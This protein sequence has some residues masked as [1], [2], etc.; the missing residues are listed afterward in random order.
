[1]NETDL[2]STSER[3][4]E[5]I[6]Q[7]QYNIKDIYQLDVF[8]KTYQHLKENLK[9]LLDIKD[10]MESKGYKTPYFALTNHALST[11]G[12]IIV[13]E[14]HEVN[15][16]NKYF[17]LKATAKKNIY[18]RTKSA[19]ASH[20]IILGI[21][22]ESAIIKC[23]KCHKI[24]SIHEFYDLN[25]LR[26]ACQSTDFELEIDNTGFSRINIIPYLPI[27]GNYMVLRS[28][29][30]SWGRES[31]NKIM[32]LLRQERKGV[33]KTVSL[34]IKI[35]QGDRWIRKNVTMD[36]ETDI[37]YEE[38]L[39]K[40]Y[41][42]DVRLEFLQFQRTKPTIINDKHTRMALALAY[43]KYCELEVKKSKDEILNS[44][45]NDFERLKLYDSLFLEAKSYQPPTWEDEEI[46]K[47]T[48]KILLDKYLKENN[49]T[50]NDKLDPKIVEDIK[51]RL[52]IENTIFTEM[53][54]ILISWDL[55]KYYL[56]TSQD[57][58]TLISGP[59]QYI[60]NTLDRHQVKGFKDFNEDSIY[61]LKKY[62]N[63]N[64]E[65][66]PNI[67]NILLKKFEM[68]QKMKGLN[69]KT[70][71]A[72][73]GAAILNLES[74]IDIN[75]CSRLFGVSVKSIEKEKSNI[76]NMGKPT[77]KKAKKFL[78]MIKK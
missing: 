42:T 15:R 68:E 1:M 3:F 49:L 23:I 26:C 35:K 74:G 44:K 30:T 18:D 55:T 5:K 20:K 10:S 34:K 36:A 46:I 19:I 17:R 8:I 11:P 66:I 72:A 2:I 27:S 9:K 12:E 78:E 65:V 58:R 60:R 43:S 51:L 13:E 64:I 77:T 47:E 40:K 16:H 31:F 56:T 41:G 70:H 25:E 45:L 59:F 52:K 21:L 67:K 39:R 75:N 71:H 54:F 62:L 53:P 63:E 48:R 37:N 24:Y 28:N 38:E 7:E 57:K 61:I 14:V 22:E 69:M 73:F 29:L 32:K 76:K 33:V 4:L 50:I 6:G